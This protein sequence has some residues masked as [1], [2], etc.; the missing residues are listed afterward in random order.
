MPRPT[1]TAA[2]LFDQLCTANAT[3]D[4][5]AHVAFAEAVCALP[6][7]DDA[8]DEL[9]AM[10]ASVRAAT[11]QHVPTAATSGPTL[12]DGTPL[13]HCRVRSCRAR[14]GAFEHDYC[15]RCFGRLNAAMSA[16]PVSL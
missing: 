3:H 7:G 13:G 14:L 15:E 2:D 4:R 11:G 8:V 12:A 6:A 16:R 5:A 1:A 9:L 10:C